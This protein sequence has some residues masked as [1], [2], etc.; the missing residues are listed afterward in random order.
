MMLPEVGC[1]IV[2]ETLEVN[3]SML[4]SF[5]PLFVPDRH[6]P[7]VDAEINNDKLRLLL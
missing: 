3:I 4:L 7:F 6:A 5:I 1:E 2:R